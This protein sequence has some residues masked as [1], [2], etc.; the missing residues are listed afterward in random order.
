MEE[1][2]RKKKR[3]KTEIDFSKDQSCFVIT[4]TPSNLRRDTVVILLP[5]YSLIYKVILRY[6][7]FD[8]Y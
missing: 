3:P 4:V 1:I 8:G 6:L 7:T 2:S 5:Y